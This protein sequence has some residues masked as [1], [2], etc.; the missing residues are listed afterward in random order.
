MPTTQSA[1]FQPDKSSRRN[2]SPKTD[3]ANQNQIT[4]TNHE[5]KQGQ[6]INQ[7]VSE[8]ESS[9]EKHPAPPRRTSESIPEYGHASALSRLT[10]IAVRASEKWGQQTG[11]S[12]CN[13][14]CSQVCELFASPGFAFR[15]THHFGLGSYRRR[16]RGFTSLLVAA[17]QMSNAQ[18]RRPRQL[19][20]QRGKLRILILQCPSLS[21]FKILVVESGRHGGSQQSIASTFK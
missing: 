6:H 12:C 18:L 4:N 7:E 19:A 3:I 21:Q 16:Y 10:G 14:M 15:P 17:P 11:N 8:A 1:F 5:H 2:R 13:Q 20:D 9:C